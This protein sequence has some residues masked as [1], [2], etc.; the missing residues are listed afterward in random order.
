MPCTHPP[1]SD[2]FMAEE[3]R[4]GQSDAKWL[5]DLATRLGVCAEAPRGEPQQAQGDAG[6]ERPGALMNEERAE[7]ARV[8]REVKTLQ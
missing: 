3:V 2:D 4:L 1:S 7:R 8:P 5:P 6:W